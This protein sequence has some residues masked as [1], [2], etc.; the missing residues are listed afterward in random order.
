MSTKVQSII[1]NKHIYTPKEAKLWLKHN[2]YTP[3][4]HVDITKNYL[5]YRIREPKKGHR[6]RMINFTKFIKAVI[7]I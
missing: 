5:R 1:F 4:K 3:I 2:E 7:I 6:Y